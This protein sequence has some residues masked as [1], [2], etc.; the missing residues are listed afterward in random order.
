MT[1]P[2]SAPADLGLEVIDLQSDA[3]F[4]RRRIHARDRGV[5]LEGMQRLARAF[6]ERPET[7]LQELV[8]TAVSLCGAD[9]A[10]ISVERPDKTENDYYHWIATAGEY[11]GFL[12]A[13]LPRYPSACGI[14][15]ERGRP[16]LFRVS[17][18][19]FEIMGVSAATVTDGI[20][21]PWQVDDRQGAVWIMAHGREMA[22][23]LEDLKL[24]KVLAE[25]AA[26]GVRQ[27]RQ[28]KLL[29]DKASAAAAA[30]MAD[31]LAHKINNPLQSLTNI[32]YLAAE[33]H[34]GEGARAVG[35]AALGDLQRLS[36]LVRRLLELPAL[37][38]TLAD[39]DLR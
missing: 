16:Q 29:V 27:Q 15:L 4:L 32:L 9:S 2:T 14:C 25:F 3:E 19:F 24:M 35:A 36:E 33:G 7:I 10:G 28:Q 11:A 8:D 12:N 6:V 26:M 38:A 20:L 30:A 13:V 17:P 39:K 5:Q 1:A 22:F 21:L 23:D 18:R 31:D 37:A 34:N